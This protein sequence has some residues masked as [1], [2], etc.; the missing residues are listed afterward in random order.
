MNISNILIV[1]VAFVY[2]IIVRKIGYIEG[3][4]DEKFG[5]KGSKFIENIINDIYKKWS[6][7]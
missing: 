1:V 6:K 4:L 2:A 7:D 3:R 5:W